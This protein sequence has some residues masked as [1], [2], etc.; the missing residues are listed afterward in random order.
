MRLIAL[1]LLLSAT[2]ALAADDAACHLYARQSARSFIANL[3]PVDYAT[4]TPEAMKLRLDQD[5][6]ECRK[7]ATIV[8][9]LTDDEWADRIV[10]NMHAIADGSDPSMAGIPDPPGTAY[11][12]VSAPGDEAW[13]A[14]CAAQYKSFNPK[15]GMV[16]QWK[17]PNRPRQGS[18]VVRCPL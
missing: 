11:Q 18:I 8:F 2:P 15:T 5:Y 14:A 13:S 7:A 10:K 3:D 6:A 17:N 4:M 1:A 9:T 16:R 12:D